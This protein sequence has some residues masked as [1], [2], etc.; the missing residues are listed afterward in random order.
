MK[1]YEFLLFDADNTLLDF[2][3]NEAVAIRTTLEHFGVEPTEEVVRLYSGINRRF[4][5]LY[6]EGM[7]TQA[8]VLTQRFDTLFAELG[9]SCNAQTVEDF[10]RIQ[11]GLGH[12]VIPGA[13]E[14]LEE[15]KGRFRL[16]MVSN[17]VASTQYPRLRQS[18]LDQYFEKV[19]ISE[20][21]GFH[22]PEKGFFDY[23]FGHVPGIERERALIIGDSLSS[24]IRGGMNAGIDTCYYDRH[25]N[26]SGDLR[27]TVT[28]Y[29]F[30]ALR[31][32]LNV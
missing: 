31:R 16:I 26:G 27:P 32:F 30:D 5:K 11:L 17:G 22:K 20:E 8:Q 14:L 10:Y 1:R 29:D 28:V 9:R 25:H 3:A 19:F 6:D 4:W 24:D 13:R 21:V 2:D 18:G 15:L 7:L 23:V 12:Q